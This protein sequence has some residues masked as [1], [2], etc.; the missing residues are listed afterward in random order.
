MLESIQ[1]EELSFQELTPEEKSKR[2]ILGRL[3]GPIASFKKAT[4]NDRL[5]SESLWDK[6]FQ[7]PIVKE[8]FS[9][10]GL[11]GQLEHPE[12]T[13]SDPMKAAIIM[14][15]PPK[16]DKN[17]HLI[18]SV[19]ILDTPCGKIA[20]ALAKAGFKFGISSRGEGDLFT[21]ANG[22][23][24][25]D[26][27]TYELT[28]FDLV[29]LPACEDARLV[30]TES[31]HTNKKFDYKTVLKEA[32]NSAS[33]KDKMLMLETLD[34]LHIDLDSTEEE[35][36]TPSD[37]IDLDDAT[38]DDGA[39]LIEQ[40]QSA[41]AKNA[42]LQSK[43]ASAQKNLSACYTR[44]QSLKESIESYKSKINKMT[45]SSQ[46]NTAL[47]ARIQSLTESLSE[48]QEKNLLVEKI[49]SDSETTKKKLEVYKE[50]LSKK[51]SEISTLQEN[52]TSQTKENNQLKENI[53]NLKKD[54]VIKNKQYTEALKKSQSIA[55]KYKNI[56]TTAVNKYI[57]N[58]ATM[59]GVSSQE[60][61]KR[62]GES[63]TFT[64]ID[65]LCESMQK[66]KLNI[67]TMPFTI[68]EG[69]TRMTITESKKPS[70]LNNSQ[71]DYDDIDEQFLT[72]ANYNL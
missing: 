20:Y 39:T 18:A 21:N 36:T 62:L 47:K 43:L 65:K 3:T 23:E 25:V 4:R 32:V 33:E 17:G 31:Y 16:K 19:D 55:T 54:S 29:T 28:T 30:F 66:Y 57:E 10:G 64:D 63:Y 51:D 71:E 9:N 56:A 38:D 12:S 60:I 50:S 45:N 68:P 69:N 41:L 46:A 44:E 15:D 67:P 35:N 24:E 5:Y 14:R 26:P 72:M 53:A 37:D 70:L 13:E 59:L 7:S 27:D 34:K 52:L 42:E 2:G 8:M 49:K 48:A 58:K 6:A 1:N 40:L 61:K 11:I 22:K